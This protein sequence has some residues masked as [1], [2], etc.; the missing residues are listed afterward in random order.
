MRKIVFLRKSLLKRLALLKVK[1]KELGP[2]LK[3][4]SSA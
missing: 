2:K 3:I 4:T 1:N